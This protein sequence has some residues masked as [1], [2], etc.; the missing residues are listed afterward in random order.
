MSQNPQNGMP[1][2]EFEVLLTEAVEDQL[3]GSQM[4]AFRSHS[5]S[6][7]LCGPL[8]ADA[9]AGHQSLR[10]LPQLEPPAHLMH[11]ILA[12]TSEAAKAAK[13]SAPTGW[14]QIRKQLAPAFAPVL[15]PVYAQLMQPRIAGSIAMAF[16]SITLLL[17][18]TGIHVTDVKHLDLRPQAIQ[19]NVKRSYVETTARV[20]KYYDSLRFVYEVE[21]RLRDL[22]QTVAPEEQ[23]SKP[24][25]KREKRDKNNKDMSTRPEQ[26]NQNYSRQ[27]PDG[28]LEASL[29]IPS[30]S[31][32]QPS[33]G[34]ERRSRSQV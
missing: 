27:I 2:A 15:A 4:Q 5:Q 10:G 13:K 31:A 20:V 26:E 25:E 30:H 17:N 24:A 18:I 3:S 9:Q 28:L 19:S 32:I 34:C 12:A 6:C 22:K 11:N 8:F 14:Q 16:F 21:S 29:R 7:A 33:L 1:C 23:R